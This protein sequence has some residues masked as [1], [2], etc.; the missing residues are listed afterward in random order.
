M[1]ELLSFF[2]TSIVSMLS[3]LV[4]GGITVL[5]FLF[6]LWVLSFDLPI[7]KWALA[8]FVIPAISTLLWGVISMPFL[9]LAVKTST[10]PP[11]FLM[12]SIFVILGL[13]AVVLLCVIAVWDMKWGILFTIFLFDMFVPKLWALIYALMDMWWNFD[14]AKAELRK[15]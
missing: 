12:Y 2:L 5:D 14:I 10:R 4:L 6:S 13:L 8:L 3:L 7:I 15:K 11:A 1:K 9:K